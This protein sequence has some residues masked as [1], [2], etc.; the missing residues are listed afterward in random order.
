M[1]PRFRRLM[2]RVPPVFVW[3]AL[4]SS[5]CSVSKFAVNRVGDALASGGSVYESDDDL[6]LVGDA[7]PFSLK[8]V[9][10]LLAE[11]TDHRGLLLT[12]CRGFTTYSYVYVHHEV[13]V[14]AV[15]DRARARELRERARRLYLR[16][17]AYGLRGLERSYPGIADDL[18]SNPVEAAS[19]VTRSKDVPMLYW[20][21]ASLGLAISVSRH[22]ATLLARLPE[23]DALLGRAFALDESWKRGTLHEFEVVF[24]SARPGAPKFDEMESHFN[25]AL[26]LSRGTR[27]GLYVSYAEAVAVPRQ[28]RAQF[29]SLLD[30]ALALD[31][32]A[33]EEV[34]LANLVAQRRARWLRSRADELILPADADGSGGGTR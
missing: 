8:F 6:E 24:A 5:G 23:V 4:F 16:A 32:D 30:Q 34:R 18:F 28:D 33:Y 22:D 17:H 25:R 10:S 11:S 1:A 27:A 12:A 19:R 29:D 2:Q 21:A 15:R 3:L 20:S 13:D 31:P 9:E 26:E 14:S 7:L